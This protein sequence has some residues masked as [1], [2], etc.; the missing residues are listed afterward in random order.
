MRKIIFVVIMLGLF[1]CKNINKQSQLLTDKEWGDI[2]NITL[3]LATGDKPYIYKKYGNVELK[4]ITLIIYNYCADIGYE[5]NDT[6]LNYIKNRDNKLITNKLD[7]MFNINF[8]SDL[9]GFKHNYVIYSEPFYVNNQILCI[10]MSNKLVNEGVLLEWVFFLKKQNDSIK[11]I[12][13]Y[14]DQKDMFFKPVPL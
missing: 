3:P 6:I 1:G 9:N 14:D 10:S 8:I 12:K 4:D 11:I 13:F 2:L 5:L 7:M